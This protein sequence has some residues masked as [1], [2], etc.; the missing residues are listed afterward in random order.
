MLLE[1]RLESRIFTQLLQ[2]LRCNR[3]LNYNNYKTI[4]STL[5]FKSLRDEQYRTY[6][7]LGGE[8]VT[9]EKPVELNVSQ[10]G[11]HRILDSAGM[12]HYIPDG[13]IQLTWKVKKGRTP[14]AF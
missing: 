7:F 1:S 10:S 13:W 9:I 2:Y 6:T 11:G 12:S 14:F 5:K 3:L 4:M 8:T